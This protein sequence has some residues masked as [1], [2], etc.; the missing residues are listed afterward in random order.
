[1]PLLF[2]AVMAALAIVELVLCF[3]GPL[4]FTRKPRLLLFPPFT[5]QFTET[6]T[7]ELTSFL[8]R[9]LALSNSYSVVSRS[10]LEEYSIRTTGSFD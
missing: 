3:S 9:E 8:E 7:A 1:M 5:R 10:F 4:A 2:G 6:E